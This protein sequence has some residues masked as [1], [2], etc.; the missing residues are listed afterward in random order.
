MPHE[1]IIV[2]LSWLSLFQDL[3]KIIDLVQPRVKQGGA[4]QMITIKYK[5][6]VGYFMFY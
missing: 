5:L 4:N 2:Q 1:F 6:K 3:N